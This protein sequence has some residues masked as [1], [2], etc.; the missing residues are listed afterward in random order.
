MMRSFG[1][2]RPFPS[3]IQCLLHAE[4]KLDNED[5][6]GRDCDNIVHGSSLCLQGV[7]ERARNLVRQLRRVRCEDG[8]HK[9]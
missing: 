7:R 5:L 3:V 6:A 8:D 1:H 9:V 2:D 4:D